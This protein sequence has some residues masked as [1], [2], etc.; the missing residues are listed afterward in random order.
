LTAQAEGIHSSGNWRRQNE[1]H[2]ANSEVTTATASPIY[3]LFA[4]TSG[5]D[6]APSTVFHMVQSESSAAG[7]CK[8]FQSEYGKTPKN[9]LFLFREAS[10]FP[11]EQCI[12]LEES[13]ND[14]AIYD[15]PDPGVYD[16][17][18]TKWILER[19]QYSKRA[20]VW[21]TLLERQVAGA[22]ESAVG[23]SVLPANGI[24]TANSHKAFS[25]SSQNACRDTDPFARLVADANACLVALSEM[26]AHYQRLDALWRD[27]KV[28]ALHENTL[29][30]AHAED[31]EQHDEVQ[32]KIASLLMKLNG[33]LS[34]VFAWGRNQRLNLPPDYEAF[35]TEVP[36]SWW[37]DAEERGQYEFYECT[38]EVYVQQVNAV[39][40]AI[41]IAM[42]VNSRAYITASDFSSIPDAIVEVTGLTENERQI[43]VQA[44]E[45]EYDI[46]LWDSRILWEANLKPADLIVFH[47]RRDS[48]AKRM[49]EWRAN[50]CNEAHLPLFNAV[51]I[52]ED[53]VS[54]TKALRHDSSAAQ[55]VTGAE[56]KSKGNNVDPRSEVHAMYAEIESATGIGRRYFMMFKKGEVARLIVKALTKA[57]PSAHITKFGAIAI[58][59]LPEEE[60]LILVP[61]QISTLE[62]VSSAQDAV[63]FMDIH[64]AAPLNE[65]DEWEMRRAAE[66]SEIDQELIRCMDAAR[67]YEKHWYHSQ[68]QK[69]PA[70]IEAE[71]KMAAQ[72]A[73]FES[74]GSKLGAKKAPTPG[75]SDHAVA[76]SPE[77]DRRSGGA[78]RASQAKPAARP[79]SML[80][81]ERPRS[82]IAD[83]DPVLEPVRNL[84]VRSSDG[85]VSNPT[86]LEKPNSPQDGAIPA[87]QVESFRKW[88]ESDAVLLKDGERS[89]SQVITAFALWIGYPFLLELIGR[90]ISGR[91]LGSLRDDYKFEPSP[92]SLPAYD[93]LNRAHHHATNVLMDE[94]ERNGLKSHALYECSNLVRELFSRE[95]WKYY[96]GSD[97]FWPACLG[98]ARYLL[99][100][101]QQKAIRA[102]EKVIVQ[103]A[104]KPKIRL[105]AQAVLGAKVAEVTGGRMR[106]G[107]SGTRKA[108]K[109][110][111]RNKGE[112]RHRIGSSKACRSLHQTTASLLAGIPAL[113]TTDGSWVKCKVAAG[114][115]GIETRTLA[116]YRSN[117]E[118]TRDKMA[119]CDPNG[120]FWRRQGTPSAHPWYLRSRLPSQSKP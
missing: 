36:L 15:D 11:L 1:S 14:I 28:K 68:G 37:D 104:M 76:V 95:P 33:L 50:G 106:N 39:L 63:Q 102:G 10:S 87:K 48:L 115:E 57:S 113:N 13:L 91:Y 60:R 5:Q 52:A 97:C 120:R 66:C 86:R 109:K 92:V 26:K 58:L 22:H 82:S 55:N 61:Q 85:A 2:A 75:S 56:R 46:P 93:A 30:F 74:I 8:L 7:L 54:R 116:K 71:E 72:I 19:A 40:N 23:T 49:A 111:R 107:E 99:P 24:G 27:G 64:C 16:P 103:L 112:R 94:A 4:C 89:E 34:S 45:N 79:E 51:F 53:I 119:G 9:P 83:D 80:G 44:L 100:A 73:E 31:R 59:D 38:C 108:A 78:P 101:G 98:N 105:D 41:A 35:P 3:Y 43:V 96:V 62:Q 117:G 32:G 90:N 21:L 20:E 69:T 77:G 110:A 88:F 25:T 47:R 6:A 84:I 65:G 12:L 42:N 114:L 67:E 17:P 29:Q 18:P 81:K 70:E 118:S